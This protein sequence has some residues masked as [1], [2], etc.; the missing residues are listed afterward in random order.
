M[1][2][3]LII[4]LSILI[5]WLIWSS[6]QDIKRL[7][8]E[9]KKLKKEM[10]ILKTEND[11]LKKENEQHREHLKHCAMISKEQIKKETQWQIIAYTSET[12]TFKLM[13]MQSF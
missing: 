6:N 11:K 10:Q 12:M 1:K 7:E 8:T 5:G 9:N 2:T 4:A 13:N 3:F